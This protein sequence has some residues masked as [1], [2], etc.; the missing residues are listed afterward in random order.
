MKIRIITSLSVAV[1]VPVVLSSCVAKMKLKESITQKGLVCSNRASLGQFFLWDGSQKTLSTLN[2]FDKPSTNL[3]KDLSGSDETVRF[4][5]AAEF[6]G[7]VNLTAQEEA[8][9]EAEVS[10][11][12]SLEAKGLKKYAY[13]NVV[14]AITDEMNLNADFI[15]TMEVDRA[16]GS[17]GQLLYVLIN[18]LTLG[19]SLE[20]KVEGVAAVKG[21]G[22]SQKFKATSAN[23]DFKII[24]TAS[25]NIKGTDGSETR[26]FYRF[27]VYRP[28]IKDGSYK[29]S[30]VTNRDTL[31]NVRETLQSSSF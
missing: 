4:K 28:S 26:L 18:E 13:K 21:S 30:R 6:A 25:L 14:K 9:L 22:S 12:S 24:D 15:D 8:N 1:L 19:T 7:G 20:T 16:I 27:S 11:M 10:S 2:T 17:N 23:I 5:S 29:F 3:I 31:E